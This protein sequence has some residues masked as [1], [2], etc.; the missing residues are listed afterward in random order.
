MRSLEL[1]TAPNFPSHIQLDSLSVSDIKRTVFDAYRRKRLCTTKREASHTE[2]GVELKLEEVLS[3]P[4]VSWNSNARILLDGQY[5]LLEVQGKLELW[6]VQRRTK[7]WVAPAEEAHHQCQTFDY[8]IDFQA[9]TD[10]KPYDEGRRQCLYFATSF[11]REQN[12]ND[13]YV[14]A[15]EYDFERGMGRVTLHQDI[16]TDFIRQIVIRK[17]IVMVHHTSSFQIVLFNL[18]SAGSA[19]V[20]FSAFNVSG[21]IPEEDS[22]SPLTSNFTYRGFIGGIRM[23][24][25]PK[26]DI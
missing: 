7:L 12:H 26:I 1:E 5:L 8:D 19:I 10:D 21:Y 4:G 20:D 25:S 6:S 2:G 24:L 18:D 14:R 13:C 15:Y 23:L 17:K 22:D 16:R 11:D 9:T 3:V